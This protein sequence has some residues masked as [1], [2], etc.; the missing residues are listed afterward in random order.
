MTNKNSQSSEHLSS[1]VNPLSQEDNTSGKD[2]I[3]DYVFFKQV[4]TK[5]QDNADINKFLN[6]L[7]IFSEL[8]DKQLKFL[9]QFCRFTDIPAGQY[10]TSEGDEECPSGFIVE[11]GRLSMIKTSVSGKEL[12]V[13]LL[14]PGDI[15]GIVE[16]LS[17]EAIPLQL[18]SRAQLN[19]R[20][21]WVPVKTL[22]NI[23]DAHPATYK[24]LVEHLLRRLQLSYCISRGLAHD[25][26]EVRIASILTTLALKFSRRPASHG[27]TIDI[28]RQQIADLTGTTPETAIRVTR[29]M[30]SKGMIDIMRPGVVK[31]IDLNAIEELADE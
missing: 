13:E 14:A 1:Q 2:M 28:T 10:I 20:V 23:L 5:P 11:S 21:L 6:S 3:P 30:Q 26:V 24:G 27:Q 25:K 12:V 18:S 8:P 9:S 19:S 29:S 17:T 4:I 15:F 16:M 31:I 22:S 7:G